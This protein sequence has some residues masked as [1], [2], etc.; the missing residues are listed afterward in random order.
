MNKKI[1]QL[2]KNYDGKIYDLCYKLIVESGDFKNDFQYVCEN[3]E[4]KNEQKTN[5]IEEYFQ[6]TEIELLKKIYANV[7]DGL[8]TQ[9]IRKANYG[10]VKPEQFYTM[11][12]EDVC[13]NFKEIKELAFALYWIVIDKRIPY[14]YI[15]TPLSMDNDEF[16]EI[17]KANIDSIEKIKYVLRAG[18]SQ[19]T[20]EASILLKVITDIPNYKDQVVVFTHLISFLQEICEKNKILTDLLEKI[21]EKVEEDD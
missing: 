10:I 18:Y 7:V 17:T 13:R 11:L 21:A 1:E 8:I 19:R 9:N 6:E 12:W 15:G 3:I 14:V 4:L 20:E 5:K 16:K 2:I